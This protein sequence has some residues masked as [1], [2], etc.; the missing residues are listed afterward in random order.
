MT[1][2][3]EKTKKIPFQDLSAAQNQNVSSNRR[4]F[5]SLSYLTPEMVFS[6]YYDL[7][8]AAQVPNIRGVRNPNF[9]ITY[10]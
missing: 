8:G 1:N 6:E 5:V 7:R 3:L 10:T 9:E 2:L 4:M